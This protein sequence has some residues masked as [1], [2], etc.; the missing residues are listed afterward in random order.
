LKDPNQ[1]PD[2]F[3]TEKLEEYSLDLAKKLDIG[4]AEDVCPKLFSQIRKHRKVLL[5]SYRSLSKSIHAKDAL[6]PIVEWLVDNF[7]IVESQSREM[8]RDMTPALYKKLPK[9]S[10]GDLVGSSRIYGLVEGLLSHTD[11]QLETD[12]LFH[13]VQAFQ[14]KTPL[15]IA[16]L[17]ALSPMLKLV[18][19]ENLSLISEQ[20]A[21]DFEKR[22]KANELF[23]KLR[24]NSGDKQNFNR[25]IAKISVF[26]ARPVQNAYAFI[27]QFAKRL[28]DQDSRY[29]PVLKNLEKLLTEQNF[30]IEGIVH[31][32]H[33]VQAAHQVRVAN[34]ITSMRLLSGLDWL[35]FIDQESSIDRV[36]EMDPEGSYRQMDAQTKNE[37]RERVA[38]LAI[39]NGISEV[40]AAKK[41]LS[42]ANDSKI[43]APEDWLR[44][45]VGYYLIGQGSL[46]KGHRFR[47]LI[48]RLLEFARISRQ[49]RL[50]KLDL[51]SGVRENG[52]T[53]IVILATLISERT[54]HQLLEKI[55]VHHLANDDSQFCFAIFSEF[56][57]L[58]SKLLTEGILQ[59]NQKY[60]S[61]NFVRNHEPLFLYFTASSAKPSRLAR[62]HELKLILKKTENTFLRGVKFV[63]TIGAETKLP[64]DVI[65]RIVGTALH[66][67]NRSFYSVIQPKISPSPEEPPKMNLFT[68]GFRESGH[69][70]YD[71]A[72]YNSDAAEGLPRMA[73]AN[74][75]EIFDKLQFNQL[76]QSL[77]WIKD[78][79]KRR[80]I[81][82]NE[83]GEQTLRKIARYTWNYFSTFVNEEENSLPP[84]NYQEDPK[85][86]LAHR[87]SPTNMGVY[88]LSLVSALDLGYLNPSTLIRRL[89]ATLDSM[90]KLERFNGHYF[91]WYDTQT[92]Q[93]LQPK[94]I[95]TADSGNLAGH[96]LAVRQACL[97]IPSMG[98]MNV[99]AIKG[100]NDTLSIMDEER[101][102]QALL[103][104]KTILS[105]PAPIFFSE[106]AVLLT[107]LSKALE[108]LKDETSQNQIP[109]TCSILTQVEELQE[110]LKTFAPWTVEPFP[111]S[112][113]PRAKLALKIL[114]QSITFF[115]LSGA[116]DNSISLLEQFFPEKKEWIET[117]KAAQSKAAHLIN[118]SEQL[119]QGF[120]EI[121]EEMDFRFLLDHDRGIFS[122]G[123]NAT[124]KKHDSGFYDLLASESRL[125][126]FVAIAKA[127]VPEKHWFKLGRERISTESGR[128]LISWSASMFEYL[129]P[130][131]VMRSY[132]NTLL[133]ET[134]GTILF[135]QMKYG[136]DRHI[137]WGISEAGF[138][139]RDI[140]LN[141]QY[142]PFG[143]P[144]LGFKRGL[145]RDL[146]VSP[147]STLLAAM[148]CPAPALKNLK[149]FISQKLL[150]EYGFYE[151]IDYTAERV[152]ENEDFATVK[153]FMA[154]H[155]GMSLVA[156][157]NVINQNIMQERF[158]REPCV[159]ATELLLQERIPREKVPQ[160][161]KTTGREFNSETNA[162]VNP[163]IRHYQDP[164]TATP[165]VQL[166]SN[167][168]YTVM[169]S[170]AGAGYS[171]YGN[172]A[173][174]RWSEDPTRDQWGSYIFIK[175]I[176]S[177]LTWSTT[178]QPTTQVIPKSYQVTF[179]E[180][181]AD[182]ERRD[183]DI[184]THTEILVSSEKNVEI[185]HVTLTNHSTAPCTL[186]ITSYLEPV[187]APLAND[188][189][190][191]AFSK[192]FIQT[193]F[194]AASNALFANRRKQ[195]ADEKEFWA[196]HV[197]ACDKAFVTEIQYETNREHFIGR[198][199]TI[200]NPISIFEGKDLSNTVGATLD[201][202]LSLRCSIRLAAGEVARVAFTTG[203]AFSRDEAIG[204]SDRY[205]DIHSFDRE[206]KLAWTKSQVDLRHLNI[207][208]E[209]AYLF[210]RMAE[211]ILYFESPERTM[212][213]PL[214]PSPF[215]QL[216]LWA[217][218]ISGDLPMVVVSIKDSRDYSVIHKLLRCHEYLRLKGLIYD[219]IILNEQDQTYVQELQD[220]LQE[221]IRVTGSES[222]LNKPGGIFILRSDLTPL[223]HRTFIQSLA[224]SSLFADIPLKD[225]IDIKLIPE[226][227]PPNFLPSLR[228]QNYPVQD[229]PIPKTD[230]FNEFGGFNNLDQEYIIALAAGL[231][232]PAPWV[233]VIGNQNEFGFQVSETGSGFTWSI[234]SQ[235]N[236]LT[237]WSNDPVS[238]PSGEIIY[239]RDEE[240]GEVW[241]PTPLPIRG[242]SNYIVKHGQGYTIFDHVNLGVHSTLTSFVPKNDTVKVSIL[243]LKNLTGKKRK[244]SV[245]SY[246]EWVL[247]TQKQKSSSHLSCD[248]DSGSGALFAQN[249]Y[250]DEF[251]GRVAFADMSGSNERT[252]TCSRKEF[253]GRNGNYAEPA[254][255]KRRGLSGKSGTSDD[256]CAALQST[257]EFAA[258]EEHEIIILLGQCAD[259][260]K[261]REL[262][263]RY[264]GSD[265]AKSAFTEVTKSWRSLINTIQVKTPDSA[266][267]TLMNSWLFYQ[268]LSCRFWSRTAFY[269]SGG[270]YGFRDQLQD[271]MAFVY[272]APDL[273]R[274]HILRASGRQF[275]EGDVQHWWHPP[276]GR[277]IRT[278]MS[279]DLVW[280]PFVVSFYVRITGD[281][282]VLHEMVPFIKAPLL[283]PDQKDS[284]TL[285]E[286]ASESVTVFDHCVHA[287]DRAS[288]LGVHGLPLMGTGDWNDS[289]NRV[290]ALG[291]G[292]SIWLGW[293]LYK[294]I[295]DFLPFCKDPEQSIRK[296]DYELRLKDLKQAL[297]A[298]AWDGE[299][300]RRAYFDDGT[301]LG[302]STN[303]ECK[304]D[305]IAQTWAVLSGAGDPIRSAKAMEKVEEFLIQE[306]PKLILLLTPAFNKS[307][308]DPGY[309]KGYVP[310]VREN[311]GQYTH[312]AV[313]T[314]MAYAQ[315]GNGNKAMEC[316]NLLNPIHHSINKMNA[317]KYKIEPYVLAGD[318]YA[319]SL[320]E[321]RGGWSWYTGSASWYYRSGLESILGFHLQGKKLKIEPCIP[322]TWKSYEIIYTY[323]HTKYSIQIEN[324]LA[325]NQGTSIIHLDGVLV[326]NSEVELS[327]DKKEHLILVT[328]APKL[329]GVTS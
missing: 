232:T 275:K 154:H 57:G 208:S 151:S 175:N 133:G 47:T 88:L 231:W 36:L 25:L 150:T 6:P 225:Q 278:R 254:A 250:E 149:W 8:Q 110:D 55:E 176:A 62:L 234:N 312:A 325:L 161:S 125:A 223:D 122:I 273:A 270:A 218:G 265:L 148:V 126:S 290:G 327:D 50:P 209:A 119:A 16:E 32:D 195:S 90:K 152:P 207:D 196:I 87:T 255:L 38:E 97:E 324:P 96:L 323:G 187:L 289:M 2:I 132:E 279:D 269:Q 235:I 266:L 302:S 92:L 117:F 108:I 137:P 5:K 272:S 168:S 163:G 261:A 297:D 241:T 128:A 286:I 65:R 22:A 294:T 206:S 45:H 39:Q 313:W 9:L 287:I 118:E 63:F 228:K 264:R 200:Q 58:L 129:M 217:H 293:F 19:I 211:K 258:D 192:L 173:M 166:L 52:R 188:L 229:L 42:L 134:Y 124:T 10:S 12:T 267:D 227:Y 59:L 271:C 304:I 29:E 27:S 70:L 93:P 277:G 158:H 68:P 240:T 259:S 246:T 282:S 24:E 100:L 76:T 84:D 91:N 54:V 190:H 86:T 242:M 64:R 83:E 224:R 98:V 147:Y 306:D 41:I 213:T 178:Y 33:Q 230:F 260:E 317:E 283:N 185:R 236:R 263:L 179:R 303:E 94:Y 320:H 248:I 295:Q 61:K 37:Y 44:F 244:I 146:V 243:S 305:S 105:A 30:T 26:C 155:Q 201:P 186:E 75:I 15:D 284:Y 170:T 285:P 268:V 20:T 299:W 159:K 237:P 13:F 35:T 18:L 153:S 214:K 51:S 249:S 157:N 288:S 99:A 7:H 73:F 251:A 23:E 197:I 82:L 104:C 322:N 135:K 262:S 123:Y 184:S 144:G 247:G 291:K 245:T 238:D 169:I 292:E 181:K 114:D 174:T 80:K 136:K 310:G 11:Y 300:Y 28:R 172:I 321:G 221:E 111:E 165:L 164:N 69:Y 222:W 17:W 49:D 319:G 314:I 95:S 130:L 127:D 162:S 326:T 89:T 14:K 60:L 103:H 167:D 233:N 53:L 256:P 281:E 308:V 328:L 74:E 101:D 210:Q 220:A 296:K 309:I 194:F 21:L 139:A 31:I 301:P 215:M 71:I 307:K 315:M 106:W 34:I 142:G 67:L 316:F 274:E 191:P 115:G 141:Y 280:L 199:R 219:F 318:V 252:F 298:N 121:F 216:N 48:G 311:G 171:K 4:H 180:D 203:M 43:K 226:K 102:S 257:Y 183:G 193:E 120:A 140:L 3:S 182:F 107:S 72:L 46:V 212:I 239:L 131:L 160:L 112:N 116:Y 177:Q 66:P 156:I 204:L 198:G 189:D 79:F 109:W 78:I 113:D 138:N 205:H 1:K 329:K 143:I 40:R 253:L 85:S 77:K 276:T 56:D 145:G 81:T 202:I